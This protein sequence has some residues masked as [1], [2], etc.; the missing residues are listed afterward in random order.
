MCGPWGLVWSKAPIGER[1]GPGW[2]FWLA[3]KIEVPFGLVLEIGWSGKKGPKKI[4][5]KVVGLG[6]IYISS[7][8]K[9]SL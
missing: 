1:L 9:A 3:L 6:L 4:Y 5:L 7:L 8:S 2:L